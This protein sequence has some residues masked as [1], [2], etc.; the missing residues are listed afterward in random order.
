VIIGGVAGG[1]TAAA[2]AMRLNS[3]LDITVIER[4]PDVSFA[5]CGLPYH[6]GKEITDRS[7]LAL[8]TPESL[9]HALNIKVLNNTEATKIDPRSKK[10]FSKNVINGEVQEFSYDALIF[11]PGASPIRPASIPGINHPKVQTL[12]NLQ[13]MDRIIKSLN[14]P[15]T[16]RVAV[17]G[18]GFIGLEMVE[19][20]RRL[21]KDVYLIEKE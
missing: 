7:R 10:V 17:I 8:H 2:R 21:G 5:N 3:A 12:R 15:K 11:S 6:I 19:Q 14:E 20:L 16:K 4:S 18:A 1:A 13:D 9:S